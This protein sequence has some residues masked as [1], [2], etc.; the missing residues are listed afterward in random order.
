MSATTMELDDL[1][2]AWQD[3]DRKLDRQ[4]SLDLLRFRE[5]RGR[6][7]KSGLRPLV[8]GQA[9]QMLV[10]VAVLLFGVDVW[11]E[12]GDVPHLLAF[13]LIVHVYGIALI[14]CGGMVQA[15][16]AGVDYAAPV[17]DIQKQLARL[18]KFYVRTG[19]VVGLS[20]WLFWMPFMA[21]LFMSLFGA[22]MY[23]NA[24]SVFVIGSAIGV[25]GLLA[26][27]WFH[28]WSRHPS[29][30]RLARA[31]EDSVT[32]RSLRRAQAIADE[33]ARF[34]QD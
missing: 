26:T 1:K 30:P 31:M 28:R 13:G 25:A 33:I 19:M 10:G 34:E 18:R 6:K 9:L 15:M 22:D 8:W 16:I 7:M 2:Q 5:E 11:T 32:G 27:W 29:R 3:L 21:A 12:H 14:A 24:P 20:W 17:L 4:Y 23:R